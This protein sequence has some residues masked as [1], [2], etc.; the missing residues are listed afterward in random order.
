MRAG[1]KRR[2]RIE[3]EVKIERRKRERG[4][5]GREGEEHQ[6]ASRSPGRSVS[7]VS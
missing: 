4:G 6:G 3:W 5:G 1:E 2:R 7:P